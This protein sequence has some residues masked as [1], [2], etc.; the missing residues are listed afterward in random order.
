M[1]AVVDADVA[2]KWLFTEDGIV[3][4]RQLLAH[5]VTLHAPDFILTEAAN[6]I[7]KK[8]RRR[9]ITDTRP[10]FEELARLDDV[11]ELSPSADLLA[12]AA[13]I[14][15][16][17]DHPVYDCLYLAGAEVEEAP[18]VTADRRLRDAAGN[19]ADTE[20]WLISGPET[21]RRIASAA[22]SLVIQETTVQDLTAAYTVFSDTADNV[23]SHVPRRPGG[24]AILPPER[25]N[26]YLETPAFRRL[27]TL[28]A[29][30][31]HEE[32]IDLMALAWYGRESADTS[33]WSYFLDHACRM[34]I[35]DPQYEAALGRYW[36][37]GLDR[38]RGNRPEM[39]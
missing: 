22:T 28:V 9:E 39:R 23:V 4:A 36:Q 37:A 31:S 5:R 29:S 14:A 34:G 8:A 15:I 6:V 26:A 18:L 20:V 13:A 33:P 12:H 3:E 30:L 21:G 16:E 10:Y 11:V 2:V 19:R 38:L 17:I 25:R 35:D 7:W 32:R 24:P 27:V 1:K